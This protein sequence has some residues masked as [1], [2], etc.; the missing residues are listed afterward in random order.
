M[1]IDKSLPVSEELSE[2]RLNQ[3]HVQGSAVE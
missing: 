3:A 2:D 1:R